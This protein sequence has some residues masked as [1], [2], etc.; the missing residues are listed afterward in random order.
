MA[1]SGRVSANA[2]DPTYIREARSLL[3]LR[4]FA[5]LLPVVF[6]SRNALRS[7]LPVEGTGQGRPRCHAS[8]RRRNEMHP[9]DLMKSDLL[10]EIV[11]LASGGLI[12]AA[13]LMIVG[14]VLTRG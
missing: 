8:A 12:F 14:T 6:T 7:R 2:G 13:L 10:S 1:Q 4:W 9:E 5:A 11:L 3:E